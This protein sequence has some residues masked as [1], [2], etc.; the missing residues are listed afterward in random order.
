MAFALMSPDI[1]LGHAG[2][3]WYQRVG[4]EPW[5]LTL[6]FTAQAIGL[7]KPRCQRKQG[8]GCATNEVQLQRK[9]VEQKSNH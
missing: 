6:P 1:L 3:P 2:N 7:R 4:E 9:S 5:F 8:C